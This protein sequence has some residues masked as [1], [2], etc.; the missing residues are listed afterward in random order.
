MARKTYQID[1]VSKLCRASAY[2]PLW[3]GWQPCEISLLLWSFRCQLLLLRLVVL[4]PDL[5]FT[6]LLAKAAV[7]PTLLLYSF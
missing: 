4:P 7:E 2:R 1:L 5:G 6:M 3:I